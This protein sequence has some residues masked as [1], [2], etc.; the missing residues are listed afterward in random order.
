[1]PATLW[2]TKSDQVF[3]DALSEMIAA[4]RKV[5]AGIETIMTYRRMRDNNMAVLAADSAQDGHLLD[6][7]AQENGFASKQE[8]L[9]A[10]DAAFNSAENLFNTGEY[11]QVRQAVLVWP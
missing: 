9:D 7:T 2:E 11:D 10:V 8:A 1:M 6:A 4:S 5:M 3:E